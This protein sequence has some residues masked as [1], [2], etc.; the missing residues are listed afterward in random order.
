MLFGSSVVEAEILGIRAGKQS[1]AIG[2]TDRSSWSSAILRSTRKCCWRRRHVVADVAVR[3]ERIRAE[4]N[5]IADG[6]A[7]TQ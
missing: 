1:R 2:S 6:L 4:V 7:V 3:R 5:A